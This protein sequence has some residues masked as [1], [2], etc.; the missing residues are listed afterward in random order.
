MLSGKETIAELE[1]F[2]FCC[3]FKENVVGLIVDEVL[4]VVEE[5]PAVF[6]VK[7]TRKLGK[8]RF[9]ACKQFFHND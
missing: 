4:G 2:G 6:A 7:L 8:P 9:V 5:N 3:E 1:N